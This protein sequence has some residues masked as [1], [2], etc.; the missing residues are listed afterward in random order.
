MEMI[1]MKKSIVFITILLLIIGTVS[2]APEISG[3]FGLDY[4]V[5]FDGTITPSGVDED[6]RAA[7]LSLTLST[8]LWDVT[9][10]DIAANGD[11]VDATATLKLQA[12]LETIN[13]D[14][15]FDID[16]LVGNQNFFSS[17]VYTDPSGAE[18]DYYSLYSQSITRGNLPFGLSVSY[19]DLITVT[20]GY[21]V[22]DGGKFLS[23]VMNPMEGISFAANITNNATFSSYDVG[24]LGVTAS[25]T[26][27]LRVLTGLDFDLNISGSGWFA[28]DDADQNNYFVAV[29]GGKDAVS[30]YLEFT[31]E[32]T[33]SNINVGAGYAITDSIAT[34]AGVG[35][36][37]I[38]GTMALGA[39]AKGT[40][41]IA[42]ITTFVKY[43]FTGNGD[44]LEEHYVQ[45]GLDFSF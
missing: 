26:A 32:Q 43:G 3:S 20:A 35:L 40:Y 5:G 23:A 36:S 4:K 22:V 1:R 12:L 16:A 33:T 17:S 45:T 19:Q 29:N 38:T 30:A 15:P 37:D 10:R 13:I 39:W 42:D 28:I 8:D 2:A 24:G 14:L 31:N 11:D 34:S 41:T 25:A 21:D 44:S 18:G 27:D 9:L 7:Q 6:T